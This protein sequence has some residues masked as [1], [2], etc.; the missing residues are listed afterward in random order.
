GVGGGDRPQL[1]LHVADQCAHRGAA[2]AA[3]LAADE[4]V[5][6]DAGSAFVDGRDAH[7]AQVLGGA[8]LLDV[9][10]AAVNLHAQAGDLVADFR[11]PALDDRREEL[12]A[13]PAAAIGR[14]HL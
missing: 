5:R 4:I 14:A 12:A 9:A 10:H 13:P 2:I 1:P 11:A 7:I 8:G 6:L 3:E